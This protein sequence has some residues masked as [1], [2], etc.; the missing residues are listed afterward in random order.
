MLAQILPGFR[1]FRTP[2]IAG[3]LWL[4][5]AWILVGTP[6]PN[7]DSVDG[8]MG[9]INSFGNF[10]SPTIY[11]TILSFLAYLIGMQLSQSNVSFLTRQ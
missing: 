11:I 4:T 2:L 7:P 8:V 1:D 10:L 5:C 6:L 3:Y 9:A